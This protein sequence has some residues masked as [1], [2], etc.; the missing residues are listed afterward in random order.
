[1]KKTIT[2]TDDMEV[3]LRLAL[4]AGKARSKELRQ[5]AVDCGN[6]DMVLWYERQIQTMNQVLEIIRGAEWR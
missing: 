1:M 4:D 5:Y 2:I 6:H 3:P